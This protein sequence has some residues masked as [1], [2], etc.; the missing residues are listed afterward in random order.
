MQKIAAI[1]TRVSGDSQKKEA[2]IESQIEACVKYAQDHN[3]VIPNGWLIKDEGFKGGVFRRPG[4]EKLRDIVQENSP[5]C[6]IAL[7]PDRLARKLES[8]FVLEEE[9]RRV[10]TSLAYVEVPAANNAEDQ[11]NIHLRAIFAEY[12][13]EKILERC[14]R[15]RNYKARQGSLSVLPSAP[16]GYDY[17][18]KYKSEKGEYKINENNS[19]IVK[20]IYNMYT[21]QHFP[22]LKICRELDVKGIRTPR[23][24]VSWDHAT[25]R[26]IL[27]NS[28]YMGLAYFGKTER[29]EISI[30]QKITRTKTGKIF[31]NNTTT[32]IKCAKENWIEIPVPAFIEELQFCRAQE[33]LASNKAYAARNTKR[34][35]IL[36]GLL[37]CKKCGLP[38]YK[39]GRGKFVY[40][41]CRSKLERKL[42]K[43]GAKNMRQ[44]ILDALVWDEV[45]TLLK[46]PELITHELN[47]R[48]HEYSKTDLQKGRL[49]ELNLE[50]KRVIIQRDKLLDA[51]QQT[52]CLSMDEFKRRMQN[53]NKQKDKLEKALESH[54]A[55]EI[56]LKS[57]QEILM[58][59]DQCVAKI[60]KSSMTLEIS[61]KQKILRLLIDEIIIGDDDVLI[62]HSIPLNKAIKG[63]E[64]CPLSGDRYTGLSGL[65]MQPHHAIAEGTTGIIKETVSRLNTLGIKLTQG[66]LNKFATNLT[67]ILVNHGHTSL[68]IFDNGDKK[69]V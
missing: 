32:R 28:T 54:K 50:L 62:K 23:G 39:K 14:R 29:C 25:V 69:Q 52:E 38:L 21:V 30:P 17:V 35:S 53:L 12:E 6:V 24:G 4:L 65:R 58:T 66:E 19:K 56:M 18:P 64:K 16:F 37:I 13:R 31:K 3:Y 41:C 60:N 51:Y 45:I 48:A 10:G 55:S 36:Q 26:D 2:T 33:L 11:M 5:E 40:Y 67:M 63:E 8:Q 7:C 57:H 68:N 49:E 61:E 59:L 42:P 20:D 46:N 44:D 27:S 47:K 43:C 34:P 15:G 1:Y 9:F 22:I